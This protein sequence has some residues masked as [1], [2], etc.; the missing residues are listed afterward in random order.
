MPCTVFGI[1]LVNSLLNIP[2]LVNP[3]RLPI[4]RGMT[5][6]SLQ[7]YASKFCKEFEKL[8]TDAG[9]TPSN[10]LSPNSSTR[11]FLQ[12]VNDVRKLNDGSLIKLLI[13]KFR[14]SRYCKLPS[15]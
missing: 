13:P 10:G 4:S 2:I 3:V 9:N 6:F 15:D 12:F 11:S 5:P 1:C 7:L 8:P 14:Y